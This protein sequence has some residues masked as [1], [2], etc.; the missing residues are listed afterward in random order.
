MCSPN[1]F[2]LAH[3]GHQPPSRF[4]YGFVLVFC[5]AL[6]VWHHAAVA[7]IYSCRDASG[8]LITSDRPIPECADRA[9]TVRKNVGQVAREIPR[10]LTPEERKKALQE[11]EKRKQEILAEEEQR[12]HERYLLAHYRNED[13]LERDRKEKLAA[14]REK[15]RIGNEQIQFLNKLLRELE[16]ERQQKSN[17]S[18]SEASFYE[19]RASSLKAS[20]QRNQTLNQSYEAELGKINEQ[21]DTVLQ[22]YREIIASKKRSP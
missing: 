2:S 1:D 8:R 21:F 15:I 20:L 13:D 22:Q 6:A 10:P 16:A 18:P 12:K 7:E 9:L 4:R 17:I 19:N 3:T 14:V 5:S 11:E